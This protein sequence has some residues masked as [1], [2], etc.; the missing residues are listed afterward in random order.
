ML[1]RNAFEAPFANCRKLSVSWRSVT[2]EV[3]SSF[4][5]KSEQRLQW[6]E[7]S[8][9]FTSTRT[10]CFFFKFKKSMPVNQFQSRMELNIM[11]LVIF[12]TILASVYGQ[13]DYCYS[14]DDNPYLGF[15]T[16]SPYDIKSTKDTNVPS[17]KYKNTYWT[18]SKKLSSFGWKIFWFQRMIWEFYKN[19]SGVMNINVVT[20]RIEVVLKYWSLFH[21]KCAV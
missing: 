9:S 1:T 5:W 10:Q 16:K 7:C 18:W 21:E 3:S 8:F 19:L 6:C 17:G 12:S 13:N 20:Y 15:G 11:F 14:T 4:T 2:T